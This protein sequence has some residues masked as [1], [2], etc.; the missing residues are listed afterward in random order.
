MIV[1]FPAGASSD[2]VGRIIVQ[3]VAEQTGQQ[4]LADNRPGAGGNLGLQM[5]A[6]AAPDGYTIGIATASIAVSPSLYN[7]LG[8]DPVK[9]LAPVARLTTI[10]N[11]L[12][13]H[14]S[15]PAK[16]LPQFIAIARS[17][18]GKLNY[19]SGG[20]GTTNHLANELL[21]Y[22]AKINLV[23]VPYKGVTQA[24]MAM[25]TGEVDEVVMPVSTALLQIRTG[26]VRALA[27]LTEK[28]IPTLPDV[29]TGIEQG[30]KEFIMPVWYGMFAPAATPRELIGHLNREIVRA[31]QSPEVRERLT[32][33]GVD[34][35]P[36]TAEQLG[37]LLKA[38]I[39]RYGAVA[40]SAGLQ[41]Q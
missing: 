19:G 28:R 38:E 23:H 8:Y 36:G 20:A 3:K 32:A 1:A 31:L 24:M 37:E 11:V 33:M 18:P 15:V 14:P 22:L 12:L 2:L 16:T 29:P 39:A 25:M 41:K 6:K 17:T 27:V 7:N 4:V 9:D 5:T 40:R 26:K 21:K 30:V 10:P 13:V 35:W 34:P